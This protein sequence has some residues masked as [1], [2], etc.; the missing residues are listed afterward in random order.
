M[1]K[2]KITCFADEIS[3]DLE[4]QLDVLALE[5]LAHIEIRNVWG[6]N[7]LDLTEAELQSIRE[8]IDQRDFAVS[9]VASPIGKYPIVAEFAPQL[10]ALH[11]AIRAAKV[12]GTP[13]IRIFSYQPPEKGDLDVIREEVMSRMKQ[14]TV[15]AEQNKVIL[16][17]ENDNHLYGSKDERLLDILQHCSSDSMRLAFDPGNFVMNNV[18]PVDEAYP[19]LDRYLAYVHIKDAKS[20]TSQFVPAGVG[21]GQLDRLLI[22]LRE[23]GYAGFLSVEPH[24]HHYLPHA[25]NPKRVVTAVRALKDLLARAEMAWE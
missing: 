24:L 12:L 18:K 7:V 4:E 16:I 11:L 1:S 13:F 2:V 6:K 15:I 23:S 19:K 21:E 22:K 10:D 14:L 5:G 9:S 3:G 25:S 17:L 20:E 8:L